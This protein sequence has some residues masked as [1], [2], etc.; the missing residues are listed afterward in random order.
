MRV[1]ALC[2][3]PRGEHSSTYHMLNPLLAGMEDAGAKTE[4]VL[5]SKL[6]MNHCT[7]CYTCWTKTPGSCIHNDGVDEVLSKF[8]AVDL[9]IFGTPLYHFTMSGLLKDFIDRTLPLYEPW[10]VEDKNRPG[11]SGHPPRFSLPESAMLLCPC[12]FPEMGHFDPFVKWFEEYVR[13][14]GWKYLG[15]ILRPGAEILSKDNFQHYLKGYYDDL[16]QAGQEIV[17]LGGVTE[18][19]GKRLTADLFPGGAE[20]FRKTANDYWARMRGK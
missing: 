8:V 19:L 12:G 14:F 16:R 4:L 7:G 20:T 18:E 11:L 17:Q 1:L 5:L 2:G 9:I 13:I 15:A 6:K 3:S 10:L